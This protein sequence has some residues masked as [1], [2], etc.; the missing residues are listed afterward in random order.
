MYNIANSTSGDYNAFEK[1][2]EQALDDN[3]PQNT[4]V[5]RGNHKPDITKELK[6]QISI[7]SK[8]RKLANTTGRSQP[9]QPLAYFFNSKKI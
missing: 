2:F 6:K 1:V 3:M 7:R 9:R 5:I 4:K 8:L